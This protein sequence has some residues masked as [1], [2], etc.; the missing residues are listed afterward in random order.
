MRDEMQ[1]RAGW[2]TSPK[3]S[4]TIMHGHYF[5][6]TAGGSLVLLPVPSE[7]S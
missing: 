2:I 7:D 5:L 4:S 3:Q 1:W 6:G